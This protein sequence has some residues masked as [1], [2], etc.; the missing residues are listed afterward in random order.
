[1]FFGAF[2]VNSVIWLQVCQPRLS[3]FP[4]LS[5][6]I[7]CLP[8]SSY[9][10]ALFNPFLLLHN[11]WLPLRSLPLL[12]LL[13]VVFMFLITMIPLIIGAEE[14]VVNE[15]ILAPPSTSL[16]VRITVATMVVFDSR[17]VAMGAIGNNSQTEH[18]HPISGLIHDR[19]DVSYVTFL[20]T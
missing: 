6:I 4:T 9:T 8:M 19:S 14:D 18:L 3:L 5:C 10:W 1:M 12:L 13:N 16:V 2:A 7:T 11:C 15:G 20:V 17:T